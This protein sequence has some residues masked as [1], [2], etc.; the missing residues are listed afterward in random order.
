MLIGIL[1]TNVQEPPGSSS[2]FPA[3]TNGIACKCSQSHCNLG[4]AWN[5]NQFSKLSFGHRALADNKGYPDARS[6]SLT[7][8]RANKMPLL[9]HRDRRRVRRFHTLLSMTRVKI[10]HEFKEMKTYKAIGRFGG[11]HAGSCPF[12]W[13]RGLSF[14]KLRPYVSKKNCLLFNENFPADKP[15]YRLPES[16]LATSF[17][18]H[19]LFIDRTPESFTVQSTFLIILSHKRA[20]V[21]I[22]PADMCAAS[23]WLYVH[24]FVNYDIF[25]CIYLTYYWVYLHQTWGV[26]KTLH[27]MTMWINSWVARD[28]II[29]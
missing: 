2:W 27:F 1:N 17:S 19:K 5:M 21:R 28:V 29:F 9:N 13:T 15:Q 25:K 3:N 20:S 22:L 10:E 11:T 7:P 18:R 23:G 24:F 6:L 8:V 14:R 4:L 26:C 12:A 16:I